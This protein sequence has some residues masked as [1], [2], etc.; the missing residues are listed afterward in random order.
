M[1][2]ELFRK[3]LTLGHGVLLVMGASVFI[4]VATSIAAIPGPDGTIKACIKKRAPGK[5]A[6]RVI[7]H[8]KRCSSREVT[9]TWNQKGSPGLQGAP[10]EAGAPGQQ[11][12]PGANGSPDG[13]A[14]ILAKL[15]GVDGSGSGL[16]ADLL[17]GRPTDDF[18]LQGV[19]SAG[20]SPSALP[21]A[22]SY[23]DFD[24]TGAAGTEYD[25]GAGFIHVERTGTVD[26]FRV[27]ARNAASAGYNLPVVIRVADNAPVVTTL[28]SADGTIKSC[29]A[30]Q[31]ATANREFTVYV[32]GAFIVGTP[33]GNIEGNSPVANRWRLIGFAF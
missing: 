27:C 29:T 16:D 28:S 20:A 19:S 25:I 30:A 14:Q 3:P 9:L 11:G 1:I 8:N 22:W 33:R 5:G 2:A 4:L 24:T 23:Y 18:M 6:L 12:T 32:Q 26:Q 10:G 17:D 7:D 15:A 21:L 13:G 31:T